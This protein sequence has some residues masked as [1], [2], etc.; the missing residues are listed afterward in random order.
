MITK[1]N[2]NCI[3]LARLVALLAIATYAA[4]CAK[5]SSGEPVQAGGAAAAMQAVIYSAKEI[6][7]MNPKSPR[8]E[9][10]AVADGRILGVGSRREMLDLVGDE[11][12]IDETFADKFIVPGFID[13]H[14]HPVLSALTL[15][16]EIIAIEDWVLPGKTVPAARDH[17]EYLAR[18]R[19]AEAAMDDPDTLLLSW[20]FHHYFHGKLTRAQLDAI[21]AERPIIVWHRSAHEFI[22]NTPALQSSGVTAA[23]VKAQPPAIQA[24]IDLKEGHF[25]ERGAFEFLLEKILP[26]IAT[27]QRLLAGLQFTADYLHASGVTTSA[28]PGGLAS[29]YPAQIAVFGAAATPFRFYFIPD[30]REVALRHAEGDIV[31]ATQKLLVGATGNTAFLQKQVKLFA[32][33]AIFSQLMQ[34]QDGYTDNHHGEWMMQPDA[35]AKAFRVYWD[36][37]YQIHVHQNGD[38]GLEMVLDN[39]ELNMQRNPRETTVLPSCI[40]ALRQN[41]RCS[42][43]PSWVRSSALTLTIRSRWRTAIANWALGLNV[44]IRWYGW[45]MWRAPACRFRCTPICPWHP[46]NRCS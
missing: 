41:S 36:A 19:A 31:L 43:L 4:G 7:T 32:D 30:G 33:G 10:V 3:R 17:D 5:L 44:P 22:L 26:A 13:Q 28:E 9:A 35:F 29:M 45:V 20:G 37:G 40:S 23:L 27:P 42:E 11:A 38:A 15:T 14:L 12:V 16:S 1:N 25:W 39:L 34:M 18:L 24:Q 21:T 6:I 2:R 46:R 8:G